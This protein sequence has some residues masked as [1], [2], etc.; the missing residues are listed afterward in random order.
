MR[1]Y[2]SPSSPPA[3]RDLSGAKRGCQRAAIGGDSRRF[4]FL[5][6]NTHCQLQHPRQVSTP[7]GNPLNN[8]PLQNTPMRPNELTAYLN[9]G[10]FRLISSV[11]KE[12]AADRQEKRFLLRQLRIQKRRA[13]IR[14][15][16]ERTGLHVPVFLIASI[17]ERCNLHC[18]G[19]YA[20]GCGFCSDA[21]KDTPLSAKDWERIFSEAEGLGISFVI[22]AGGSRF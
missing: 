20:R 4:A 1:D 22:L 13:R 11:L 12:S 6:V 3:P 10:V 5:V 2:F 16:Y 7:T 15:R 17:T 8:P 14:R 19:C 9:D 18:K 21:P